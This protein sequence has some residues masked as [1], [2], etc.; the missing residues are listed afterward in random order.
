MGIGAAIGAI[1]GAGGSYLASEN[2]ADA[3]EEAAE[4]QADAARRAEDI[5]YEMYAQ[6]REDY[7]PYREAGYNILPQLQY[8][9]TGRPPMI[10]DENTGISSVDPNFTPIDVTTSPLYQFRQREG[11]SAINRALAD[12]GLYDSSTAV[13]QLADL[14]NRLTA[15]ETERQY[16]RMLDMANIGRGAATSSGAAAMQTGVTAGQYALQGGQ[17]QAAGQLGAGQQRSSM[18]SNLGALPMQAYNA[19]QQS[20][21]YTPSSGTGPSNVSGINTNFDQPFSNPLASPPPIAGGIVPVGGIPEGAPRSMY[22]IA[23]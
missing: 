11:E 15:E 13:N 18:Y 8:L 3:Q 20:Q 10:T 2:A 21:A 1:I 17:A 14:T 23:G 4:T 16:G 9:T 5:N 19:Y 7:A 12:R 22:N 6:A